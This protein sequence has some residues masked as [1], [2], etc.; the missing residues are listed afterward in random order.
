MDDEPIFNN[1]DPELQASFAP[2]EPADEVSSIF[3]FSFI[4]ICMYWDEIQL[5][6]CGRTVLYT[7]KQNRMKLNNK[8]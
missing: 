5:P 1:S 8:S 7:L 3:N 2:A 4:S 6:E